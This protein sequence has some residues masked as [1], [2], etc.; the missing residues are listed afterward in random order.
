MHSSNLLTLAQHLSLLLIQL[1]NFT[2]DAF[3]DVFEGEREG[4]GGSATVILIHILDI[5]SLIWL[6]IFI[7]IILLDLAN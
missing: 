5:F 1:P 6:Q 3:R 2:A 4:K 7:A